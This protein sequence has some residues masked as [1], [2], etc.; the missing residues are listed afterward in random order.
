[1]SDLNE[2]INQIEY[3]NS[4][5]SYLIGMLHVGMVEIGN[6]LDMLQ[7]LKFKIGALLDLMQDKVVELFY[8]D[9]NHEVNKD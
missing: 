8:K 4:Q 6:H 9:E 2:Y 5:M 7:S 3:R 1:M